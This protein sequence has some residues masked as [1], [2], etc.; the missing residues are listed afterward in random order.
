MA[1]F[2]PIST[3]ADLPAVHASREQIAL[4]FKQEL[5]DPAVKFELAKDVATFAN[6]AGGVILIGAVE[7][8]HRRRLGRYQPMTERE[9]KRVCEEFEQATKERCYP[10]PLIDPV[11]IPRGEGFVV[12]VNVWPYPTQAVGVGAVGDLKDGYGG[13]TYVFPVRVGTHCQYLTPD[14]L[15]MLM[16]PHHR[17]VSILLNQIEHDAEITIVRS[18]K[19]TVLKKE[20]RPMENVLRVEWVNNAVE[21]NIPIDGI[22]SVWKDHAAGWSMLLKGTLRFGPNG[23]WVYEPKQH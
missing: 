3:A 23:I 21:I 19:T 15:A 17:H 10:K 16:L 5:S 14:Q 18:P 4:D 2:S 9:A 22:E 11:P 20:V 1:I 12:A 8:R 13:P 6:A 7:D